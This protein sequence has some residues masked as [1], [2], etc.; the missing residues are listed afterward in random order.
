MAD[1]EPDDE[2][3]EDDPEDDSL[4]LALPTGPQAHNRFSAASIDYSV[5][6]KLQGLLPAEAG[7]VVLDVRLKAGDETKVLTGIVAAKFG[8]RWGLVLAGSVDLMDRRDYEIEILA[9]RS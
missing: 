5:N 2:P 1:P 7:A 4:P 6:K 8:D 3:D 9:V